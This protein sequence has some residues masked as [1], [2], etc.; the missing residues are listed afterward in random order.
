[1]ATFDLVSRRMDFIRRED[2]THPVITTM[3]VGLSR[4]KELIV[5]IG[6]R[7]HA[8]SPRVSVYIPSRHRWFRLDHDQ[9]VLH[10]TLNETSV[11]EQIC[12]PSYQKYCI[13]VSRS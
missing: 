12:L 2:T 11:I 8:L 5:A 9:D 4:K 7:G 6:E 10:S 13:T 1:M 3:Q